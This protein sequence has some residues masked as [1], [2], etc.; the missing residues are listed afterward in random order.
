MRRELYKNKGA[1]YKEVEN[2]DSFLEDFS[3]TTKKTLELSPSKQAV[4]LS[5]S[6][7]TGTGSSGNLKSN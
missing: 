4:C 3:G 2:F 7:V 5:L 1:P 6:Q